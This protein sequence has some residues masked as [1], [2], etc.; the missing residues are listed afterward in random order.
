MPAASPVEAELDVLIRARYPLI[1]LLSW[2]ERRVEALLARLASAHGKR[3]FLWTSTRGIHG[4]GGAV[5]SALSDPLAALDFIARCAEPALFVLKDFHPCLQS[6]PVVRRLRD[7]IADLKDSRKNVVLLSPTLTVPVELEKDL[8][9]VDVPLPGADEIRALLRGAVLSAEGGKRFKVELSEAESEFLVQ[10]ALGLTLSEAEN[11]FAK[12]IVRDGKLSGEDVGA[13]LEEIKQIVRKSRVLEY[14]EAQPRLDE[15]GGLGEIKDWLARR[16]PAFGAKARA[17]G[18]PQPRGLLL[19]GVQGCGKSLV[20][21]TISGLWKMPLLRLDMGSLFGTY[22]GQSEENMR[23]AVR[24][25]EAVAPCVLW[26]DEV[27]KGLAGT[28]S[29]NLSDAGTTARVFST[30][31]TWLQ[32]KEKPVFVAMTAND[33]R[34][35]PPELLRKGRL[36]EI[37]FVDLPEAAERREIL[38]IHLRRRRR[39]PARFDL[40]KLAAA[41]EGF[42]GAELEQAVVDALHEA[43]FAGREL[44]GR[45]LEGALARSVP[46]SRTMSEDVAELRRWASTRARPAALR[47]TAAAAA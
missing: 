20:C 1:Y 37:F 5:D 12:A 39:D 14:Y 19:L 9:V 23:R 8:T 24:T 43:F 3:L 21:K 44:E 25:A 16:G 32:E 33:V 11:A 13:V 6:A 22:I 38:S 45:D 4:A 7:L 18:L 31:L 26:I 47:G 2:E 28:G 41:S 30:F 27:E 42:S 15:V 29:S 35:L 34:Q 46:L 17:F 36:D 10:A 40:S